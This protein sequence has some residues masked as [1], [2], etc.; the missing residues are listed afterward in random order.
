MGSIFSINSIFGEIEDAKQEKFVN[1]A[2][3]NESPAAS[4]AAFVTRIPF[5]MCSVAFCPPSTAHS[6]FVSGLHA[7]DFNIC[8]YVFN[9]REHAPLI[10]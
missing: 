1:A 6:T 10:V 2:I 9:N 5:L 4:Y 3:M 8:K 7:C